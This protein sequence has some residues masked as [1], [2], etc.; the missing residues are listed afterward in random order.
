MARYVIRVLGIVGFV[1]L[2][3]LLVLGT[4]CVS[5]LASKALGQ[6]FGFAVFVATL[7]MVLLVL[8]EL[9]KKIVDLYISS[10]CIL[11]A[12]F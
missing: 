11:A 12:R 3:M 4:I 1:M 10:K 8:Y 9:S 7:A 6:Y 2:A 5:G